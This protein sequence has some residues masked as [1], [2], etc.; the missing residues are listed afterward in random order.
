MD[1]DDMGNR[2]DVPVPE[3]NRITPDDDNMV[4]AAKERA[5]Q[6]RVES[7]GRNGQ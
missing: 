4:R 1:K 7:E 2:T 6:E 3:H 5:Q